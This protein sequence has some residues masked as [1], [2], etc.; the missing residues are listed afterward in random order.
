MVS[1]SLNSP[2][3]QHG[4]VKH[5]LAAHLREEILGGK[6][7]PGDT[8]AETQWAPRLGV[9]QASVREALNILA[10]EGLIQKEPGRSA[11]VTMLTQQD[12]AHAYQVRAVLEGL[13]ARLVTEKQPDL[14]DLEQTIIDMRSAAEQNDLRATIERDLAFHLLLCEKS[15]NPVLADHARLLLVPFF[16]FTLIK[17]YA[18]QESARAWMASTGD[19]VMVLDAIRSKDPAFAEQT[20]MHAVR[21]FSDVAQDVWASDRPEVQ[22][23]TGSA[24]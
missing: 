20:A 23:R 17:V 22:R 2:R 6:L 14:R 7:R 16:A 11:R 1:F 24:G 19:H 9:A 12:V 4:L 21:K 8:I 5:Q 15:G 10:N 3:Q 13:A 18:N